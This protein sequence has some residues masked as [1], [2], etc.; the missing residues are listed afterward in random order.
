MPPARPTLSLVR[1]LAAFVIGGAAVVGVVSACSDDERAPS[2]GWQQEGGIGGGAGT[3]CVDGASQKCAI[4]IGEHEGVLTCY[5][6]SQTCNAGT[7]GACSD[8]TVVSRPGRD[9]RGPGSSTQAFSP[10]S[11]CSNN[12]CDPYCQAY[13]EDPDSGLSADGGPLYDWPTGIITGYPAGLVDKG[14]KQPCSTGLDCQFNHYCEHP[15]TGN[16]CEHSKCMTGGGLTPT[17]DPCVG[18]ICAADPSCCK[19][20]Y[21]HSCAHNPCLEG[22]KLK[23]SCHPC[24]ASICALDSYCCSVYWDQLCVNQVA[25]VCG[26]TCP[27]D[28]PGAWSQSCVDKVQTVCAAQCGTPSAPACAHDACAEGAA[29]D[30][31]CHACVGKICLSDPYCCTTEWD[32]T[33]VQQVQSVCD[34]TCPINMQGTPPEDGH[35]RPWLPGQTDPN[36][37]GID[38]AA[39][40]PCTGTIPVC[41]HGNTTAPAGIRLIHFPAN[42][43]QYPKCN[44]DQTHPQMVECFTDQP[45]PPG[46]CISVTNCPQL[47]GN[48]EIMVNPMGPGHVAECT[49]K[50]N[51]TLFSG[52]TCA[53]VNCTSGY[54]KA[55]FK[56]LNLYFTVDK[57]GSMSGSKWSGASGGLKKFFQDPGSAGLGVAL[58]FYPLAAGGSFGDGCPDA[59]CAAAPCANPMV[60]LGTLTN[61]PAPTDTQEQSLVAAVDAVAPGGG[62]PT[63]PALGGALAWAIARSQTN[64]NQTHAVVLVS[65]GDPS[66][67]DT[68]AL[69]LIALAAD[70][71]DNS[72]IRT[73]VVGMDG[74]NL[75]LLDQIAAAG[76]SGKSFV[77]VGNN[78]N[79]IEQQL[80]ATFQSIS[81]ASVSCSFLLPAPG[82]FD[83]NDISVTFSASNGGTSI[84]P[85]RAG[86][87][88]CGNGWYF[89]D[90]TNPTKI[91]VC[92]D[93]CAAAKADSGS[94]ISVNIGC[95]KQF[96]QTVFTQDYEAVC[97]TGTAPIWGYFAYDTVTPSD[98]NIVFRARTAKTQ[99]ELAGASYKSLAI[100]KASPDTQLCP[101]S[102]PAPCPV[103]MYVKL[104]VPDVRHPFMQFA[105]ELNP[106][107]DKLS[108]PSINS[109]NFTYSCPPAE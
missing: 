90:N 55:V 97:P 45:I 73:Y 104:G 71:Y 61:M 24:V 31:S 53:P 105:I 28:K 37:P 54:S 43:K 6:G 68:N 108:T 62:T 30:A 59:A 47:I 2:A 35:C 27:L 12:P 60:A 109:W 17:C 8:G 23:S 48:R 39:G 79:S 49:C 16:A 77:I 1:A 20:P 96:T 29:L 100:A 52:G 103:D 81:A 7:W 87:S 33:C 106:S 75:A 91:I 5:E 92:P 67:C 9:N 63:H 38:L 94:S 14:L 84:L 102:G 64:P 82:T 85:Q 58:E 3:P 32:A 70:A 18:E 19:Q 86:A 56:P 66:E 98:S 4:T 51:W 34:S 107:T 44:P 22:G 65:D 25:N 99:A 46:Q 74:A 15:I 101:L 76:G 26:L 57:S 69:A 42:S 88:G 13:N 36:C 78:A 80:I 93:S 21:V 95:P 50:D 83:K 10:P 41:N 40:V 89:D 72:A 11:P